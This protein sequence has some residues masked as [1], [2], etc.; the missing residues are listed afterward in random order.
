MLSLYQFDVR[1]KTA[2][3]IGKTNDTHQSSEVLAGS[4]G[5][6]KYQF[7]NSNWISWPREMFT[8][9]P[10]HDR[11]RLDPG[12]SDTRSR[13]LRSAALG[14]GTVHLQPRAALTPAVHCLQHVLYS[15]TRAAGPSDLHCHLLA[16]QAYMTRALNAFMWPRRYERP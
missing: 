5:S 7:S 8:E 15:G 12:S 13:H 6:P 3:Q 9:L 1:I 4:S 14:A 11:T 16:V 2:S 10:R